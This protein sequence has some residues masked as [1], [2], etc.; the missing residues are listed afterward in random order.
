MTLSYKDAGVDIT[1]GNRAVELMKK[2]VASTYDKNVLGDIGLFSW[3]IPC[4]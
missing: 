4:F 3:N 2:A 1:E